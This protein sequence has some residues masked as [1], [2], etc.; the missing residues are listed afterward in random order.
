VL[1]SNSGAH[2]SA[3][4]PPLQL[5]HLNNFTEILL[6]ILK[7]N[8]RAKNVPLQSLSIPS[9]TEPAKGLLVVLH[10]WGA[11]A[12]DVASLASYMMLP[13]YCMAFPDA[14]FTHP[15]SEA[16]RMW[17]SFPETYSFQSSPDFG[18]QPQ[19]QESRR[20]LMEW[21]RS[22]ES[23]TGVALEQTVLAGFSQGG[24]MTLDVGLYLPLKA[25]IVLSGYLHAPIA[26]RPSA[27]P[28]VLMVHGRQDPVVPVA[29]AV[30]AKQQLMAMG[31]AVN[32]EE[33]DMG[34]EIQLSVLKLMKSFIAE[35][36]LS[37]DEL[38]NGSRIG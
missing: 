12:Q 37:D 3:I 1:Q 6:N 18:D 32:Y 27:A 14:P 21:L 34:H 22:L 33:L 2:S 8:S 7:A 4:A 16:G 5:L 28:P 38:E 23:I 30:Q 19:L 20:Q 24:A 35:R 26:P 9:Q 10:G 11:N 17:Y 36:L 13:D 25:L 31:V 15:Y 29:A